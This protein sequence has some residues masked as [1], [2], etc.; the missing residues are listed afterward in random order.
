MADWEAKAAQRYTEDKKIS[1]YNNMSCREREERQWKAEQERRK[2]EAANSQRQNVTFMVNLA[3]L[4]LV[5]ED[6]TSNLLAD[7]QVEIASMIQVSLFVLVIK[8]QTLLQEAYKLPEAERKKKIKDLR[9]RCLRN[10]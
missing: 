7:A 1:V 9:L 4:I 3:L 10:C 6:E 5:Q 8:Y 2:S